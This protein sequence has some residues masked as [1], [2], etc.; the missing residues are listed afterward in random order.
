[1]ILRA[2]AS[3]PR[4]LRRLARAGALAHLALAALT[5]GCRS[6]PD[7]TI[8]DPLPET[9]EWAIPASDGAAFLGLEV[10]END[11]GSLESLSFDPGVRVHQVVERSPA[12]A[13]GIRIDDVVVSFGGTELAVP[14]DLSALLDAAQGGDRVTLAVQRGDTVFDVE[15]TLGG[16]GGDGGASVGE[17]YV[18]DPART[19]AAWGTAEGAVLVARAKKGPVRRLALGDRVVALDGKAIVSGRGFVQRLV[20]MEPGA[21]VELRIVGKDGGERTRRVRLLDEGRRTTRF[22]IPIVTTY[23][24][25]ADRSR[26]N[27]VVLDLYVISLFRYAREGTEKRWS[28]LRFFQWNTGVGEL[29]E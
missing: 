10:R 5:V 20:A 9:L 4:V 11:S 25:A 6:A 8:P 29:E 22:S 27:F 18:L 7:R 23:D 2:A 15:V 19:Q 3:L 1:M 28:I 26:A 13:A 17:G 16:E 21:K 24:A 12:A 14:E